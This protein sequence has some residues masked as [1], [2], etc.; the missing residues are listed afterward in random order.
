MRFV[1]LTSRDEK[2][3]VNFTTFTFLFC[4][5]L[6][7]HN[8]TDLTQLVSSLGDCY[9]VLTHTRQTPFMSVTANTQVE[10]YYR[11]ERDPSIVW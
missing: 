1:S 5:S 6:H 4:F 7:G 10:E 3:L 8:R 11:I 9:L 2:Y